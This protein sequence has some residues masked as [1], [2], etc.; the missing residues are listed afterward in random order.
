MKSIA[1]VFVLTFA[2]ATLL[3]SASWA[4]REGHGGGGHGGGRPRVQKHHK[5]KVVRGYRPRRRGV[6]VRRSIYRPRVVVVHRP[7]W[8]PNR[9]FNR[10]WVFFPRYNLYWDNW[11]SMYVYRNNTIWI[12]NPVP[13]PALININLDSERNYELK[14]DEDDIDDVYRTNERHTTEYPNE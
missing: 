13:P 6:V 12:S 5:V 11:R 2:L 3:T 14:E 4:Q 9:A 7:V 1:K 10:R 8:G